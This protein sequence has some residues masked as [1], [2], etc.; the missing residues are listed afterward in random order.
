MRGSPLSFSCR[1]WSRNHLAA[2]RH[3]LVDVRCEA[4]LPY[5]AIQI[6]HGLDLLAPLGI[7]T[8]TAVSYGASDRSVS[9]SMTEPSDLQRFSKGPFADSCAVSC[10]GTAGV[11]AE[12]AGVVYRLCTLMPR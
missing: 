9:P 2:H 4:S 1:S 7:L 3:A 11:D 5:E 8:S 6:D 10:I 12:F